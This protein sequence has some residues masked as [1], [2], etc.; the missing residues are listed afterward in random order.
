MSGWARRS[1]RADIT[2]L[3]IRPSGLGG[4]DERDDQTVETQRLSED[5]NKNHADEQLR[6]LCCGAHTGVTDDADGHA[7]SETSETDRETRAEVSEALEVSVGG[8]RLDCTGEVSSRH[9]GGK[10]G[11]TRASS[12]SKSRTE[13]GNDDSNNEAVD[14]NDTS[15]D[16]GDDVTHD[17]LRAHHTHRSDTNA[18]LGGAVGGAEACRSVSGTSQRLRAAPG[19]RGRAQA[20]TSAAV[21]PMK[22]KKAG[23]AGP[24]SAGGAVVA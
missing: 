15:H 8:A 14:T 5:E 18:R 4:E 24:S 1:R 7:G 20:K 16:H 2:T 23:A 9:V 6:L 12:L 22:P 17:E 3:F 21:Q 10:F 11:V 19:E 13:R